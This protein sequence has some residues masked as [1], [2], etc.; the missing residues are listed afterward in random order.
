[1]SDRRTPLSPAREAAA[2]EADDLGT[3]IVDEIHQASVG[4]GR[5]RRFRAAAAEA[6]MA[7]ALL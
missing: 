1:M 6:R 2:S 3:Q 4:C 5:A 7:R